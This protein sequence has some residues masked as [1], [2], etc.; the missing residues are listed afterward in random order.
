MAASGVRVVA[1][2]VHPDGFRVISQWAVQRGHDLA[3]VV[4]LPG[5][6]HYGPGQ[7]SILDVASGTDVVV[8]RRL[9]SGTASLVAAVRPDLV[10]SAS[11]ARRIPAEI[12]GIPKY[13][14]VNLHPAPL[15]RGRGPNPQRLTYEGDP[16]VGATLHRLAEEFD[17]G[18]ILSRQVRQLGA[19]ELTPQ[20][21]FAVWA[22]V[23]ARALD[24]GAERALAGEP[25]EQQ[26][27]SAATYAAPFTDDEYRLRW[28]E[29][30]LTLQRRVAALNLL[31]PRAR[32][33]LDG[34]ESRWRS[35][36][37]ASTVSIRRSRQAPCSTGRATSSSCA[38]PTARSR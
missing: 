31:G 27:E 29:P 18:A 1:F 4:T 8:S 19:D 10:V 13:G 28:G 16:E 9:R 12:I 35:P 26:D 25:G 24:E 7:G 38:P 2:C 21:L 37:D 3:L 34:N 6:D 22:D 20:G 30:A 36:C 15:P 5:A 17:A 23:L 11:F 33:V 14:A 32:V